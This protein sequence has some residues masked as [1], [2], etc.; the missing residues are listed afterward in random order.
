MDHDVD[1]I[2]ITD[3]INKE[4]ILYSRADNERSIPNVLDGLKP[5]EKFCTR[6]LRKISKMKLRFLH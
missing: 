6:A 4:L 3:F 2:T 1:E 5:E